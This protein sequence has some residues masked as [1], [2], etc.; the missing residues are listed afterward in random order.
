MRGSA[1][2]VRNRRT[3]GMINRGWWVTVPPMRHP[4]IFAVFLLL[5]ACGRLP[6]FWPTPEDGSGGGSGTSFEDPS[7]TSLGTTGALDSSGSGSSGTEGPST[8]D[9]GTS[10]GTGAGSSDSSS[11][12]GDPVCGVALDGMTCVCDGV[13]TPPTADP[14]G[15]WCGA[16]ELPLE[17]CGPECVVPAPGVCLFD[18]A[19]GSC[20]C[21][22]EWTEL[23]DVAGEC[24]CGDVPVAPITC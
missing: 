9:T 24:F 12:S 5:T 10:S 18:A 22:Q 14:L 3:A 16:D 8:G 4:K 15:C 20:C 13:P 1:L 11:G 17:T 23:H 7:A 21:D 2:F 6:P 19:T